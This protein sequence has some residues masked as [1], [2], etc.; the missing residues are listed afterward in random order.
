MVEVI[1][2]LAG[3]ADWVL[4]GLSE[5]AQLTGRTDAAGVAAYYLY[6]GL[7][8]VGIKDGAAGCSRSAPP[9]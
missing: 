1:N 5:G 7:R 8:R 2:D 6:R 9:A 3:R 4:P